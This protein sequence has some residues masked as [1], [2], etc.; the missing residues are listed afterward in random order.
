M[1]A[2]FDGH[3]KN[4]AKASNYI[5]DKVRSTFQLHP[6]HFFKRE[7]IKRLV[8]AFHESLVKNV[9]CKKSGTTL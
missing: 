5:M 7:Q 6:E 3:G 8:E 1:L 9:D 4:G 2:V